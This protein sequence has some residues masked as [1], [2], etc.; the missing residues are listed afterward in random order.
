VVEALAAAALLGACGGLLN[1]FVELA[2]FL[3]AKG[4]FPW[5]RRG[6]HKV[7][8]VQGELR[9]YESAVVYFTAVGIRGVVGAAVA[10]VLSQAGGVSPLAAIVA[11]AGAYSLIDRW[12]ASTPVSDG[13]TDRLPTLADQAVKE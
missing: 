8:R 11:G 4:H 9:R 2:R 3:K 12:A 1:E 13:K 6:R 7:V 10:A 5:S